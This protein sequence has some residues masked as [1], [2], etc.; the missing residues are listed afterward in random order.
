MCHV[1]LAKTS[2]FIIL[3]EDWHGKIPSIGHVLGFGCLAYFL[4]LH[5][6]TKK[7]DDKVIKF[8]CVGYSA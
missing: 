5:N 7:I 2:Y 8:I 3:Y 4:C 6:I 1:C